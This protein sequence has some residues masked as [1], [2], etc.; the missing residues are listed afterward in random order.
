MILQGVYFFLVC[1]FVCSLI[2]GAAEKIGII[3]HKKMFIITGNSLKRIVSSLYID[4]EEK[5]RCGII[6]R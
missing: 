6:N 3:S 4:L 1:L 5:C 2:F